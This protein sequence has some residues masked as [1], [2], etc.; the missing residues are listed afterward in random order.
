[1]SGVSK[2]DVRGRLA[3]RAGDFEPLDYFLED[4]F[5][6]AVLLAYDEA[7][8]AHGYGADIPFYASLGATSE[9]QTAFAAV[10]R[11]LNNDEAVHYRNAVEFLSYRYPGRAADIAPLLAEAVAVGVHQPEYGATFLLA[12]ASDSLT[13][14][15]MQRVASA[16]TRTLERRLRRS[17]FS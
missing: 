10:L 12:H 13:P 1:M 14:F 11:A 9:R 4:E 17:D 2:E 15:T 16:V 7:M 5:R 6:L 3:E 8:S